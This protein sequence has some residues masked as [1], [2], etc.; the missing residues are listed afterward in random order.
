MDKRVLLSVGT[1]LKPEMDTDDRARAALRAARNRR[2]NLHLRRGG[3]AD[4]RIPQAA[5]SG[6]LAGVTYPKDV[7]AYLTSLR[8]DLAQ[9]TLDSQNHAMRSERAVSSLPSVGGVLAARAGARGI[10]AS[11][12]NKLFGD[13]AEALVVTDVSQRGTENSEKSLGGSATTK[14][15]LRNGN[16]LQKK[17]RKLKKF[18]KIVQSSGN[19]GLAAAAAFLGGGAS[20]LAMKVKRKF[21]QQRPVTLYERF[22]VQNKLVC[23]FGCSHGCFCDQRALQLA[24]IESMSPLHPFSISFRSQSAKI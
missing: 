7:S 5:D 17:G 13:G 18:R 6:E 3:G 12:L 22:C 4:S 15:V 19:M 16:V 9:L 14:K 10:A 23:I 2:R 20:L 8:K 21:L 11:N 1:T 24:G